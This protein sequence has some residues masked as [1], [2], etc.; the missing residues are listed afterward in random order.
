[1]L[2]MVCAGAEAQY[3]GRVITASSQLVSGNTYVVRVSGGSYITDTGSDYKAPDSQNS[4][5]DAAIYYFYTED[6]GSTWKIKNYSTGKYWGTMT[7]SGIGASNT[8]VPAEESGAGSYQWNFDG[9]NVTAQCGSYYVNRSSGTM[10]SHDSG[11]NL[12]IYE[13]LLDKT[14][15][16][17][18]NKVAVVGT[19]TTSIT[20]ATS[21]TDNDHWY[22]ISQ[23]RGSETPLYTNGTQ[24]YRAATSITPTSLTGTPISEGMKYLVRFFATNDGLYYMQF[25]DGTFI[26]YPGS[27]TPTDGTILAPTD[28]EPSGVFAFTL[29]KGATT[30]SWN[31]SSAT[32]KRMNNNGAGSTV[33][34]HGSG[35]TAAGVNSDWGIYPVTFSSDIPYSFTTTD[36]SFFNNLTTNKA[37]GDENHCNLWLS[38]ATAGKP[39]VKLIS[40]QALTTST[41]GNYM[42]SS[43]GLCTTATSHRYNLS[44]SEGRIVSYTIVGTAVGDVGITPAGGTKEDFAASASVSKKVTLASP[45]KETYFTLS[46]S[47]VWLN[48]EKFVIEYE[49]DAVAVTSASGIANDGIY[50]LAP[51]NAE[52]G[53]LYAGTTYLD[54]CGGHANTNYPANKTT[55]IDASDANQQFVFYTSAAGNTYIY[56]VG[57][58]K[59]VGTEDGIYYKLANTPVNTWTLSN[60]AYINYFHITSGANDKMATINAWVNTGSGDSKSYAVTGKTANEEANNFYITRIGTLTSDQQTTIA[61]IVTDYEALMANLTELE[62]YTIGT[63]L[64]E[65]TN[66]DFA[67]NDA[68]DSHIAEVRSGVADYSTS[69]LSSQKTTEATSIG[70]MTINLPSGK[71][72]TFYSP[73]RTKY[74]GVAAKGMHPLVDAIADAG[75]YYITND[76]KVISYKYGQYLANTAGAPLAAVGNSG[77]AFT[78][79]QSDQPGLYYVYIGGYIVAWTDGYTN[80]L[81]SVKNNEDKARWRIDA[82]PSLPVTISAARYATLYAPV[83]LEIPTGVKAFA[84][85]VDEAKRQLTMHRIE[86]VIPAN[87][88]VVLKLEDDADAGTYNF[89]ITTT[90]STVEENSLQG[91]TAAQTYNSEFVLGLANDGEHEVGFFKL[92]GSTELPGFKAYLPSDVLGDEAR[93]ITMV[94]DDETTGISDAVLKQKEES[95]KQMFDLQGRRVSNPQRGLYIVNGHKIVIK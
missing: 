71:F 94:W 41:D 7:S 27:D 87:T 68:K 24:V 89:N 92:T 64:G 31:L 34:Y 52:R 1:M 83:A 91:T 90:E 86:D 39:Q 65:Y 5:T 76:N 42:R 20:A 75:L 33:V 25:G 95:R 49:T 38:K 21:A 10:H 58:G 47:S 12:Q 85:T 81:S 56:S 77:Y 19:K 30:F 23:T 78:F 29:I 22:L 50:M 4:I 46:G 26:K 6:G 93:S 60:G 18:S 88:A 69:E 54:A 45:A 74:W 28:N 2:L 44:I 17:P 84:G 36:G 40:N 11:L 15:S 62:K 48:V 8:F 82:V 57:R 43:G 61:S 80:R 59:F 16:I 55:A 72:V 37:A 35:L 53:V 70:R 51:H 32:G 3:I 9:T 73:G 66:T 14:P 13:Y 63:G 79:S 67:T